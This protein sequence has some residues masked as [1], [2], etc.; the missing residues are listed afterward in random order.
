MGEAIELH[1]QRQRIARERRREE[2]TLKSAQEL[3]IVET[4]F[5][6]EKAGEPDEQGNYGARAAGAGSSSRDPSPN[7]WARGDG[8]SLRG[9]S[10]RGE[11][12]EEQGAF[13][14][15]RVERRVE[16]LR[17]P[18]EVMSFSTPPPSPPISPPSATSSPPLT[19]PSP[20]TTLAKESRNPYAAFLTPATPTSE[21]PGYDTTGIVYAEE[22]EA[23][24][25][26]G[27]MA[28]GRVVRCETGESEI[29]T[30]AAPSAKAL[31]KLR[32][33]SMRT[34]ESLLV[35]GVERD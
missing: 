2:E 29:V 19:T 24:S 4:R 15:P 23:V 27:G 11:R 12:R 3:S 7:R 32:R 33:V 10:P 31:G 30:P 1:S 6:R 5:D 9:P 34:G 35:D 22:P 14:A 8:S 17:I 13:A 16:E 21:E 26:L 25:E 18:G 20:T 28:R